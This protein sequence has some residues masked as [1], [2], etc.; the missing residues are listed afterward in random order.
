[1]E[2]DRARWYSNIHNW[3]SHVETL[4]NMIR[5]GYAQ[6]TVNILCESLRLS[7]EETAKYFS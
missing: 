3:E 7:P 4:R 2:R 1:M 5:N 6:N